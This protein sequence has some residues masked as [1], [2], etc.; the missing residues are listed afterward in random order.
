MTQTVKL[1]FIQRHL[2]HT[3]TMNIKP[4]AVTQKSYNSADQLILTQFDKTMD[5]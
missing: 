1:K 4:K 3:V 2:M 5:L